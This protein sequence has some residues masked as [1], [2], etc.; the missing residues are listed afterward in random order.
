MARRCA[1]FGI[2]CAAA[3]AGVASAQVAPE[4]RVRRAEIALQGPLERVEIAFA[5]G[6]GAVL[7]LALRAGERRSMSLPL[8]VPA[9]GADLEPRVDVQGDGS[10]IV[11]PS[12]SVEPAAIEAW[13]R[14]PIALRQRPLPPAPDSRDGASTPWAAWLLACAGFAL[15]LRARERG[16]LAL[17]AGAL[18][19]GAAFAAASMGDDARSEL[20]LLE[21]TADSPLWVRVRAAEGRLEVPA[22][23]GAARIETRPARAAL[24]LHV[25]E[26]PQGLRCSLESGQA[27]IYLVDVQEFGRGRLTRADPN[28]LAPLARA[29]ARDP[30]GTWT[31]RGAWDAGALL[32]PPEPVAGEPPSWIQPALPLGTGIL[33]AEQAGAAAGG[34]PRTWVR[35]VGF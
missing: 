13:S 34:G 32:G 10:A 28:D 35:L 4:S 20:V 33:I 19:G 16:A 2:A 31:F 23:L 15:A 17:L 14:L 24:R 25:A 29:W 6:S 18:G 21:G 8:P 3:L 22:D 26:G 1:A 30:D 27:A 9:G 12:A 11:A 7:E 5:D